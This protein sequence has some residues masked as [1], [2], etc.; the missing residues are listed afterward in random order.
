M[1]TPQNFL[2][3]LCVVGFISILSMGCNSSSEPGTSGLNNLVPDAGANP[4]PVTDTLWLEGRVELVAD[5]RSWGLIGVEKTDV[6]WIPY[7][8]G[9]GDIHLHDTVYFRIGH[10]L[11]DSS[12]LAFAIDVTKTKPSSPICTGN[13]ILDSW[14]KQVAIMP[15]NMYAHR[16]GATFHRPGH[17]I[18]TTSPTDA[19]MLQ[20]VENGQ[21]LQTQEYQRAL[22][23]YEG[24]TAAA[25]K[26]TVYVPTSL[27]SI[28]GEP[29]RYYYLEFYD[30]KVDNKKVL[31]A[32]TIEHSHPGHIS[33]VTIRVQ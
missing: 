14:V 6:F 25:A 17:A 12:T 15:H 4:I 11:I 20:I 18:G 29:T 32:Y 33:D 26:D 30:V 2:F 3:I 13:C 19:R 21:T 24:D 10:L 16:G 9:A 1:K 27:M 5:G 28:L 8:I 31:R 22:V 23:Q 7:R